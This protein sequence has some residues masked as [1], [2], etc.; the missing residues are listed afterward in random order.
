MNKPTDSNPDA[1]KANSFYDQ[2]KSA[3]ADAMPNQRRRNPC[4]A[5]EESKK[6]PKDEKKTKNQKMMSMIKR[7]KKIC[8]K[9]K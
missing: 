7:K 5:L 9:T 8:Q 6:L 1:T 4:S 2:Q 3:A